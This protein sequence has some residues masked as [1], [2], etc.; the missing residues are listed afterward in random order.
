M[1]SEVREVPSRGLLLDA[2]VVAEANHWAGAWMRQHSL[3]DMGGLHRG[4]LLHHLLTRHPTVDGGNLA[5]CLGQ[6]ASLHIPLPDIVMNTGL[7]KI[8]PM[9]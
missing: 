5:P 9:T 8:V 7:C 6:P 4:L 2:T 1:P 3:Q